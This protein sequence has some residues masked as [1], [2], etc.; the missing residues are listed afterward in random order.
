MQPSGDVVVTPLTLPREVG[1][2]LRTLRAILGGQPFWVPPLAFERRRFFDPA[3][4][5]WF[6]EGEAQLFHV[7]RRGTISAHTH[8]TTPGVGYFGFFDFVDD[9]AVSSALFDAARQWLR[10]RGCTSMVGPFS[11]GNQ[12]A[13]GMLVDGFD[14]LPAVG[15]T[16][17]PPY[18]E[19]H[20]R[21]LDLEL[22]EEWYAYGVERGAV[23]ERLARISERLLTRHP[24]IRIE[25]LDLAQEDRYHRIF[26]D[27]YNAA[28]H[29]LAGHTDLTLR[30]YSF[31]VE[32]FRP[33]LD[34]DLVL[35]AFVDD[36]PAAASIT[37][38]DVAPALLRMDGGLLPFGWM[39]WLRRDRYVDRIRVFGLGVDPRFQRLPL[40]APLYVETWKR[41][42]AKGIRRADASQIAATNG[43]MRGAVEKVGM[44]I[45]QTW[46]TYQRAP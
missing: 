38:P 1:R 23:P 22:H 26:L 45:T 11:F 4:N 46:R 28:F 29:D 37:L 15:N 6:D 30:E 16:W 12:H 3:K 21:A 44:T 32:D 40:G 25:S 17:N 43:R 41:A 7:P 10:A 24:E 13:Y 34:P 19:A 33:L 18:Y 27:I 42:F 35:F 8:R 5:P 36:E 9:P 31:I 20:Y 2:Y 14:Q 39:H